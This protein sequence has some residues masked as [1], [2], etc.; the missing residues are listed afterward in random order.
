MRELVHPDLSVRTTLGLGGSCAAELILESEAD[1][2]ALDARV[3]SYGLPVFI[4][5]QGSNILA[6]DG[7]H[8]VLLVRPFFMETP[9]RVDSKDLLEPD[10]P[11]ALWNQ[12]AS[13]AAPVFVRVGAG[14]PMPRLLAF[15]RDNG[16]SG[17]EGLTGIPGSVGGAVAMNA[18]SFGT[19]T[20]DRLCELS[21]FSGGGRR[22]VPASAFESGYR[23]FVLKGESE[24]FMVLEAVF[25]L[26]PTD[27]GDIA[28][29]MRQNFLLKKSRQPVGARSAGCVFSNPAGQR[30]AGVLLDEAGF[31][32]KRL[33]G[34]GFS[35]LHANFLINYGGGKATDALTLLEQAK[36]AVLMRSGVKLNYEVRLLPCFSS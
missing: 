16:L 9:H 13:G 1:C 22:R 15:C 28:E 27:S 33:H 7:Q 24:S 31:K 14:V 8:D 30:T 19:Q 29:K 23:H 26:T 4:L 21:I 17:L 12:K 3:R 11:E 25:G 2:D 5:G 32:G 36:E 10:S 34:V 6:R 18:G 20:A 35:S